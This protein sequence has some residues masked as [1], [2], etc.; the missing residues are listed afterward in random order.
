V[1]KDST[2]AMAFIRG[3]YAEMER[4]RNGDFPCGAFV[5]QNSKLKFDK[6]DPLTNLLSSV[7]I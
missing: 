2:G 6:H 5:N 7:A 4:L 1:Y 3:L